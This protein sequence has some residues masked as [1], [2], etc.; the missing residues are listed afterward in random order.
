MEQRTTWLNLNLLL[1]SGNPGRIF[2]VQEL[3][4]STVTSNE[5]SGHIS[6]D[7]RK[8]IYQLDK[9]FQV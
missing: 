7:E 2:Y 3:C 5:G 9:S 4:F 6:N 1:P 8:K